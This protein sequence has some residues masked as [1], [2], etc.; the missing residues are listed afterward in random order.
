MSLAEKNGKLWF[1]G[2]LV[3]WQN[4]TVHVLSHGLHYGTSV[5]EGVRCYQTDSGTAIFR[6]KEH[7]ERLLQSAHIIGMKIPFTAAVLEKAQ[8][9]VVEEN[10]LSS[11]YIRPLAFY[12]AHTLGIAATD[13]PVHVAI[14]AWE[15]GSYLGDEGLQ[16]G[17]R[18]KTSSFTRLHINANMCRAKVGGHYVNSVLANSEAVTDGYDE[19]LLL[20][21]QGLVAEGAGENLFIVRRGI[22]Y[23][24]ALTSVLEGITR[25]TVITLAYDLGYEVRERN[26]T[27]DAVYCADEAFFT[28]TAA[29]VT[30]IR[31]VDNR[32][33]GNGKR[34]TITAALQKAFF[35]AV[36]GKGRHSAEW[37]TP[38]A[39]T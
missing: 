12:G 7:T 1:D 25:E 9:E 14:A 34:G 15:W 31:E 39:K 21:A 38:T 19:A 17:I 23:T 29:E 32:Q 2:T 28:G 3:P 26:I 37:L 13:N 24:P 10:S 35:D 5:F 11:G 33:I 16:N 30:P 20:D 22:I 8:C 6:L 36:A 18:V 4:A 27:R